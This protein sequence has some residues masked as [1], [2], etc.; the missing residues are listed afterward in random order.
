MAGQHV[1]PFDTADELEAHPGATVWDLLTTDGGPIW[2]TEAG[3]KMPLSGIEV[4][5]GAL[6]IFGRY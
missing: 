1:L 4:A 5:L 6:A 2:W 3:H